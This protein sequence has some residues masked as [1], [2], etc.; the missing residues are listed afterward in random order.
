MGQYLSSSQVPV[1][2]R[3]DKKLNKLKI[4]GPYGKSHDRLRQ[5]YYA[6]RDEKRVPFEES[7]I[8][9]DYNFLLRDSRQLWF[10]GEDVKEF[11][12]LKSLINPY[13]EGLH[14]QSG[15]QLAQ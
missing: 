7:L 12:V 8:I 11:P 10:N 9:S 2:M 4:D 3:S 14:R 6:I 5:V 1:E 13:L 15:A